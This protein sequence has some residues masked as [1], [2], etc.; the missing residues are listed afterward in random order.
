MVSRKYSEIF[1]YGNF[2]ISRLLYSLMKNSEN[3]QLFLWSFR[4]FSRMVALMLSNLK[5]PYSYPTG[6]FLKKFLNWRIIA[7]QNFVVFCHTS[8]RISHRYTHVPSLSDLP[9]IS[10]LI[11][12]FSLSQS[13]RLSSLSHTENSYWLSVLYMVCKFLCYCF[14]TSPLLPPYI[15][16]VHP[17]SHHVHKS[18]LYVWFSIAALK[19]NSSVPSLFFFLVPS[20]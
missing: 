1:M 6:L 10:L 17:S 12:L 19:I 4:K 14:H 2:K 3:S 7:L 16:P 8:T 20:L 9:P 11:P 13:P 5:I 15:S 18:V